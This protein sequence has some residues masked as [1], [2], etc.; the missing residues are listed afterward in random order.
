MSGLAKKTKVEKF[1]ARS[2]KGCF[3]GFLE[4]SMG[5]FFYLDDDRQIILA[6]QAHFLEDKFIQED[7][8]CRMIVLNK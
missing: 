4:D 6:L 7:G 8:V 2:L 5:Y 1:E 3:D